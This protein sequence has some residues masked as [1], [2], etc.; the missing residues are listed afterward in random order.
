MF[1]IFN[2][3]LRK[4]EGFLTCIPCNPIPE[5]GQSNAPLVSYQLRH[6]LKL[7]VSRPM[8]S[9]VGTKTSV[10]AHWRKNARKLLMIF[11]TN[12]HLANEMVCF[13]QCSGK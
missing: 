4:N 1:D 5:Y 7:T 10:Q 6:L 2:V 9:I 8:E 12:F 13:L 11:L 3:N